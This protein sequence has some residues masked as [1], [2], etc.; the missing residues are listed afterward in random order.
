MEEFVPSGGGSGPPV[1]VGRNLNYWAYA[2]MAQCNVSLG[3]RN[4]IT[5]LRV[6]SSGV[7]AALVTF[8]P[9]GFVALISTIM[10]GTE[11][12][13]SL[14]L[15]EAVILSVT[16][17]FATFLAATLGYRAIVRNSNAKVEEAMDRAAQKLLEA[18]YR[19]NSLS[20]QLAL[21]EISAT[22]EVRE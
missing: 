6:R 21:Q 15:R 17:V 3:S 13:V 9:A 8:L 10:I 5:V 22:V 18:V 2:G 16:I 7:L 12:S 4:G 1:Q 20:S 19:E 11:M 14:G